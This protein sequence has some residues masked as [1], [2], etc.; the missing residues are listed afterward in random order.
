MKHSSMEQD[1][2]ESRVARISRLRKPEPIFS[3]SVLATALLLIFIVTDLVSNYIFVN[4]V[5]TEFSLL[6]T[7][8]A[9]SLALIF[10]VPMSIA[11]N[12]CAKAKVGL[13]PKEQ[14]RRVLI[15]SILTFLAAWGLTLVCRICL[16]DLLVSVGTSASGLRNMA[17]ESSSDEMTSIVTSI[18]LAAIPA[19][20][21]A[22]SFIVSYAAADPLSDKIHD[23]QLSIAEIDAQISDLQC[24]LAQCG[25]VEK[26]IDFLRERERQLHHE[27]DCELNAQLDV[28]MQLGRTI[29]LEA[30]NAKP[31]EISE[32]TA[33]ADRVLAANTGAALLPPEQPENTPVY[34]VREGKE[35]SAPNAMP[36]SAA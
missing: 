26:Q 20:T 19:F 17:A 14:A 33:S 10:D 8:I 1:L 35:C 36:E 28:L 31:D 25:D 32:A 15:L 13:I 29:V 27:F 11:G 9:F 12:A 3:R 24:G 23:L 34:D 22:A 30:V 7:V 18:L 5:I 2:H 6:V 21:S 4:K 16:R